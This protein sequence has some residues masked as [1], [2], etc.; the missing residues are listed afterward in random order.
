[1]KRFFE[2]GEW[3]ITA[4]TDWYMQRAFKD[5]EGVLE[6][7]RARY[8]TISFTDKGRLIASDNPV[9]LDWDKGQMVGFKNAEFVLYPVS[10]HAVLTGTLE[11]TTRPMR[12][13]QVFRETEHDDA[14]SAR[15]TKST[16]LYRTSVGL[17]RIGNTRPTGN[18][19]RKTGFEYLQNR[20][21]SGA[22][23]RFPR[24]L[25]RRRPRRFRPLRRSQLPG[26]NDVGMAALVHIHIVGLRLPAPLHIDPRT[27]SWLNPAMAERDELHRLV[28]TL[29]EGA[30]ENAKRLLTHFQ[31]WP[32]QEPPQVQ[33]MRDEHMER[34]RALHATGHGKRRR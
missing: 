10:R 23:R 17:M 14:A 22:R 5:A 28:D 2:S 16:P 12:K 13:F 24:A 30:L 19:S 3:D 11:R 25:C 1:M 18:Y 31:V 20:M 29:P 26:A 7:L 9:V 34:M 21:A 4:E 15:V 33:R 6:C 27:P 8:W 32:P